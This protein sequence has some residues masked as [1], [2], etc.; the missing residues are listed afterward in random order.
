MTTDFK[1]PEELLTEFR[2]LKLEN[3][4]LKSMYEQL[5][6]AHKRTELLLYHNTDLFSFIS[7]LT[8]DYIFKSKM[9]DDGQIELDFIIGAMEKIT[10]YT[11]EELKPNGFWRST[12]H[13]DDLEM[14][15][16]E[17]GKLYNNENIISE[18]RTIHKNGTCLWVKIYI[19]PIWD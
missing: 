18:M 6:T 7:D 9:T 12:I 5:L 4:S 2:E 10:G 8:T 1:T 17:L 3:Q 16:L 15:K 19:H 13:P 11:F 14:Y